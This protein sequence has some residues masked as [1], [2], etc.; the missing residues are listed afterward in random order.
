ML[1]SVLFISLDYVL[2][3]RVFFAVA[4]FKLYLYFTKIEQLFKRVSLKYKNS[5]EDAG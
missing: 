2:F 1:V 4:I 5:G 3:A